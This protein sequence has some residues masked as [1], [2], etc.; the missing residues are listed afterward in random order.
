LIDRTFQHISG[1]GPV[2]EQRLWV[3]GV[4]TWAALEKL[5]RHGVSPHSILGSG[6]KAQVL[7]GLESFATSKLALQW[8]DDLEQSQQALNSQFY[9]FFLEH[10]PTG[11]H[12]R[13]IPE[14]LS[15]AL[16]L[17]IET[18]GLSKHCNYVTV[19]G[20]LF[21]GTFH[22]WTWPEPLDDLWALLR[23]AP[24]IVTFNGRLFDIPFMQHNFRSC[25]PPRSHLDLR[26][27]VAKAGIKG[28]QKAAEEY[29][30]LARAE[31]VAG[32]DGA[33]AVALW[34]KAIYGDEDS[35]QTLLQYNRSD[36]EMLPIL[37]KRL[38]EHF[39]RELEVEVPGANK[40]G[41]PR[42]VVRRRAMPF[43]S[44][45]AEWNDRRP[46]LERLSQTLI[47]DSGE[48]PT[49]VG[50]DLRGN[51]KNPT[52]FAI[53][54]GGKVETEI[55]FTDDE[56]LH[57]TL[58]IKPSIVS[59]DAPLF[60]PRGR[61]AVTDDSPCRET[62]GIVRD[63]ERVLWS[64]Q[65][66]VYPAL[67]RHMQGLTRRGILLAKLLK[68]NGIDV[69][70]SYPGA[71][72]DILNIPRKGLDQSLLRKGL[73]DFGFQI[74][75]NPTHDELDAVTS[76]LVGYY[77]LAKEYEPIGAEEEGYMIVPKRTASMEWKD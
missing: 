70:E 11:E 30:G 53:C 22:Q 10:L 41:L 73:E 6:I 37:A 51:P 49:V 32:V 48:W 72:Q 62:G 50:I 36:V 24:V 56:I 33:E 29:F 47:D 38:Y 52:G 16:Y 35:Y 75:S 7:P 59:I 2:K 31:G 3:K 27:L 57:K 54:R 68:G 34:A 40:L 12:W 15:D 28:G 74:K 23:E 71:A 13:L 39:S 64:R 65:I 58:S 8:L 25:P 46:G 18:T 42:C 20:A 43:S 44:L 1:I 63:A 4:T 45:Q 9:E 14:C 77:Y 76:A 19:V 67:I 55:L 17:D 66:P 60:L 26:P 21:R 5:L 69:I 61:Q